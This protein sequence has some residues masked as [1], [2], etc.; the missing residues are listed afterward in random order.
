MYHL[1]IVNTEQKEKIHSEDYLVLIFNRYYCYIIAFIQS[2][3]LCALFDSI[4]LYTRELSKSSFHF[5]SCSAMIFKC[6]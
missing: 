2:L 3:S 6:L 5:F 4:D 1:H